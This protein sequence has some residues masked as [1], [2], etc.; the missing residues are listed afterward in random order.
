M[1]TVWDY[2]QIAMIPTRTLLAVLTLSASSLA[3]GAGP[4]SPERI[5]RLGYVEGQVSFRAEQ[6]VASYALPDRPLIP[7]DRIATEAGGRAE[8]SLGNAT[9]RL[10]ERSE[11]SIATLDEKTVRIALDNGTATVHLRELFDE[12]TFAVTTPNTT[13]T[14]REP[15]EYRITVPTEGTTDLTVRGG[16]A[17]GVTAGGPVRVVEGQR[18]RF[19]GRQALASLVPPRSTDAFDDWVLDREVQ[20]GEQ[21]PT[22]EQLATGDEYRELDSYGEW[23]DDS[24]YGRVWMPSYA[25]GGQ[26]PFRYGYWDSYGGGRRW[27]SSLP[28]Y[29]YTYDSGRWAYLRDRNRWCWVPARRR[30]DGQVAGNR[31]PV[32]IPLGNGRPRDSG[33]KGQPQAITPRRLGTDQT[34]TLRESA[35][36]KPSQ[37]ETPAPRVSQ[38]QPRPE[39]NTSAPQSSGTPTMRP[40]QPSSSARR[41]ATST[42]T[43]T[44]NREVGK[45]RPD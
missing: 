16:S 21:Q 39:R 14:L 17:D 4:D 27:V 12:E 42:P 25:Y 7:G 15:G 24:S 31:P 1:L 3:W 29:Y 26:D 22:T 32:G 41:D 19:E 34:P 36:M 18:V 2:D 13:L 9:L 8:L 37:R 45:I 23:Y 10:D 43:P 35:S 5:A 11:L 20:L 44:T 28:W 40:S 33:G 30:H 38:E 6:E